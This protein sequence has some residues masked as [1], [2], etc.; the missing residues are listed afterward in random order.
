MVLKPS[1]TPAHIRHIPLEGKGH[2]DISGTITSLIMRKKNSDFR[3]KEKYT[4]T[5]YGDGSSKYSFI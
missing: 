4:M 1:N 3:K 5:S 2:L